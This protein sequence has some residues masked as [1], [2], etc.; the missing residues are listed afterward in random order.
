EQ[1]RKQARM[2]KRIL[3]DLSTKPLKRTSLRHN[4]PEQTSALC[5]RI[6]S[7][8]YSELRR[9]KSGRHRRKLN[10]RN[11]RR[12]GRKLRN[13]YKRG[14]ITLNI[15]SDHEM[16]IVELIE[17]VDKLIGLIRIK[18]YG[19]GF[20]AGRKFEISAAERDDNEMW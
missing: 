1:R 4:I 20:E 10:R 15:R 16:S 9:R 8:N 3:N 19:E 7:T 2:I 12:T 17:K 6:E 5:I 13:G 11:R 14:E 18:S